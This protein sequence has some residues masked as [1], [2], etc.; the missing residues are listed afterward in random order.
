MGDQILDLKVVLL[1]S[2]G[3]AG[4]GAGA[5]GGAG[6]TVGMEALTLMAACAFGKVM[7]TLILQ[8][9]RMFTPTTTVTHQYPLTKI[10]C[11]V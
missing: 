1:G 6:R 11:L 9:W 8:A 10:P 2:M 3:G 4:T 5:G 7:F